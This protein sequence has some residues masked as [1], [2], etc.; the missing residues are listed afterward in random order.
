M[1]KFNKKTGGK[2]VSQSPSGTALDSLSAVL[3]SL[4]SL[5]RTLSLSKCVEVSK[6]RQ[7]AAVHLRPL[8]DKAT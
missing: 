5:S 2:Q 7:A 3:L 8:A 1:K 6:H 4:R